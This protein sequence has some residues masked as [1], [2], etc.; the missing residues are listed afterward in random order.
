MFNRIL[1]QSLS[2]G[3]KIQTVNKL[4]AMSFRSTPAMSA[5]LNIGEAVDVLQHK[6]SGISQVVSGYS[7]IELIIFRTT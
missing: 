3:N 5:K 4:S 1:K 2:K 7:G 6:I